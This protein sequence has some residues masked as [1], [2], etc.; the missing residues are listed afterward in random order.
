MQIFIDPEDLLE[1]RSAVTG[2]I[3]FEPADE[4][5][6]EVIC[7]DRE[8]LGAAFMWGWGD[9]EVVDR[10]VLLLGYGASPS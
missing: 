1:I 8:L 2:L 10:L 7:G 6:L 5:L 9:S 4:Q 3:S